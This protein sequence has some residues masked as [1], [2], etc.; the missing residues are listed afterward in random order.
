MPLQSVPTLTNSITNL[1]QTPVVAP[2]PTQTPVAP[3]PDTLQ[4]FR[5]ATAGQDIQ[6]RQTYRDSLATPTGITPKTEAPVVPTTG[7]IGLTGATKQAYDMLSPYEQKV[8]DS[9]ATQGIKAQTDYLQKSK[10]QKEFS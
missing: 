8:Y 2:A 10:A 6:F 3:K 7:A 5:E 4:N 9:L 1:S